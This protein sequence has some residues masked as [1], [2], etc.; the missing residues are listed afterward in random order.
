MIS[1]ELQQLEEKAPV[2]RSR[3]E[4]S[5]DLISRGRLMLKPSKKAQ[6]AP[7][8]IT[9]IVLVHNTP[10]HV[11]LDS[12]VIDSFVSSIFITKLNRMLEPLLEELVIYTHVGDALLLS[13]VLHDCEVSIEGVSMSVDLIPLE[14]QELDVILGKDFLFTQYASMDCHRKE[15]VF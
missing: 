5:D 10:A 6:K 4:Q 1:R 7:Y 2:V 13:K 9:G 14:L 11:L 12:S 15:V 8:V 3:R